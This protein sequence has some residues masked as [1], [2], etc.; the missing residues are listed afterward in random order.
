MNTSP[1]LNR[2]TA[3]SLLIGAMLS[4]AAACG[5]AQTGAPPAERVLRPLDAASL[6]D[7]LPARGG[8]SQLVWSRDSSRQ[9]PGSWSEVV[10]AAVRGF[11]LVVVDVP[12]H[13]GDTGAE[14]VGRSVLTLVV[15]PEEIAAV[16]AAR[17]VLATVSPRAPAV[18]LVS[19]ARPA[20]IGTSAVEEALGMPALA[21]V[22][23]DRRVRPAV[24]Q[25]RGPGRS[26]SLRRA[27]G[28]VLDAVG[29]E[30]S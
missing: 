22:R 13:L 10:S 21:R 14:L 3:G 18:A 5:Q 23:P 16:A 2:R 1:L 12:R 17:Q 27:A 7:V 11:D 9:V 30:R 20:G 24:D 15:V 4:P 19:V 6:A 26:R 8:V 28:T 29:L 25:G